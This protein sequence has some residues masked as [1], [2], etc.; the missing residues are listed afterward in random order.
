MDLVEQTLE[1]LDGAA[2][3]GASPAALGVPEA[4]VLARG[5][6]SAILAGDAHVEPSFDDGAAAQRVVAACQVS[7]AEGRRVRLDEIA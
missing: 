6:V 3:H 4:D 5:W 1:A 7:A 2:R